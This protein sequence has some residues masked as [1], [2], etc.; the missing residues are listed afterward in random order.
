MRVIVFDVNETL[1]DLHGL[2]P[3]FARTFGD[4]SIRQEW[5]GQLLQSALVSIVT[6]N[7][8]DFGKIGMAAL[9][10]IAVR[11]NVSLTPDDREALGQA[12]R[13]LPPHP[14][15][16]EALMQLRNAGFRLATLTNSTATVAEAQIVNAGL[17]DLF[18]QL[19]SA[20]TVRRLKPA[21][22]PYRWA[23]QQLGVETGD[24]RLVAAHAWDIAG[25]IRAG[26]ATAFVSRPGK[27]LDPLAPSPDIV[28]AN[29]TEVANLIL[30]AEQ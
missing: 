24:I 28:G 25:A 8:A 27:M 10:M 29:L 19:L 15:V 11:K 12:M 7:Y 1:L 18:E 6:D 20:D 3:F 16:R 30:E 2:D 5:F 14:E 26:C 4:A 9:E 21:A 17:N 23:A 22:E 13:Q